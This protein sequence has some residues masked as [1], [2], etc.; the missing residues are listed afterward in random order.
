MTLGPVGQKI[1]ARLTA[2]FAPVD[3]MVIDESAQHHGHAGAHP[4][5]ESH[6]RIKIV[7]EA[8]KGKTRVEQHRMVNMEL[9]EELKHR[10]H[11]LAIEAKAP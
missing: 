1:A 6:F 10:V 8:F 7:S 11:A 9:A 2:A 4:Q 3:L 5:G